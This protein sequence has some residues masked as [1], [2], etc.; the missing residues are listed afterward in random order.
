MERVVREQARVHAVHGRRARPIIRFDS[1]DLGG[2]E[3]LPVHP[4]LRDPAVPRRAVILANIRV[5]VQLGHDV[6]SQRQDDGSTGPASTIVVNVNGL[7]VPS[8]A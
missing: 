3:G 2:C 6:S 7:S 8:S 1:K 4:E 5:R